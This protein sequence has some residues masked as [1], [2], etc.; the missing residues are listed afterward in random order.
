[1]RPETGLVWWNVVASQIHLAAFDY[2][3]ERG[4]SVSMTTLAAPSFVVARVR[5]S[6]A[7]VWIATVA[8]VCLAPNLF[9]Q[10]RAVPR[11]SGE[12]EMIAVAEAEGAAFRRIALTDGNSAAPRVCVSGYDLGPASSGEFTIGG[13]LGGSVAMLAGRQG[14][15]W[16]APLHRA[17]HMPPLVVRGRRLTTPSDTLRFTTGTIASPTAPGGPRL[18]PAERKYFFPSGIVIPRRGR[19]LLIAT[20]GANWGCFILTVV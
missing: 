14:K 17:A 15:V 2:S 1:L 8:Y 7:I 6:R 3:E 18:L 9:G 11:N 4:G 10:F 13:N 16:W 20:S 12:A 5:R 19:W